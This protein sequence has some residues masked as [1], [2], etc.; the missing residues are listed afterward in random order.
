MIFCERTS[1]VLMLGRG[2][3]R[4]DLEVEASAIVVV[5]DSTEC[6]DAHSHGSKVEV[7]A[8]GDVDAAFRWCAV[9]W[10]WDFGDVEKE[11]GEGR[12]VA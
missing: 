1:L 11:R 10:S 3:A 9:V 5:P 7:D 4:S 6:R 12:E 8:D 2:V